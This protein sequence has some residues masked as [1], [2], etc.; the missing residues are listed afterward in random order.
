MEDEATT[1]HGAAPQPAA[2]L[3]EDVV[4]V[5][6]ARRTG[7]GRGFRS[8]LAT[9]IPATAAPYGYTLAI[10]SSGAVLL[11]SHGTP[12]LGDTLMF[13]IGAI[14]GFNLLGLFAIG[15]SRHATPI[16]RRQDRV[17]AG[18]LD[19]VALGAVIATVYAIS[20]VRGWTPWVLGPFAATVLYLL[21]ASLQ[22]ALLTIH[23]DDERDGGPT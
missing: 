19:W 8:S 6:A 1:K 17:L 14:A 16:D 13:V 12:S 5:S 7:P 20:Q 18:V 3:P 21:I 11:R 9:I 4:A 10:W 23:P 15:V 22:L 2:V